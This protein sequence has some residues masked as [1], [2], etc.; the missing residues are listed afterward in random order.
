MSESFSCIVS[1]KKES[2]K[3][4]DKTKTLTGKLTSDRSVALS[5]TKF[6]ITAFFL[7]LVVA[8]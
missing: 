7:I 1:S 3:Q 2:D 5:L 8:I 6:L 4:T